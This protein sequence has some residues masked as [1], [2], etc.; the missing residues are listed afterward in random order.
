LAQRS[1][2]PVAAALNRTENYE[3]HLVIAMI[4]NFA[5]NMAAAHKVRRSKLA[6][7]D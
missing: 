1:D 2:Y 6:F 3:Q 5:E 4:D 7:E